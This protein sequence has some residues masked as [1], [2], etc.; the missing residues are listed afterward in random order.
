MNNSGLYMTDGVYTVRSYISG[1]NTVWYYNK[2]WKL[3][4]TSENIDY[5]RGVF[6]DLN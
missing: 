6:F 2:D 3:L 5:S 1:E 4:F